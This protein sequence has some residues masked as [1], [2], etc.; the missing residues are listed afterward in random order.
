[1]AFSIPNSASATFPDQARVDAVDID[2]LTA[3]GR[4]NGVV[5]GCAV[6][7]TG[8]ANGSLTIT[9]GLIRYADVQRPVAAATLAVGA[10]ATGNV[11][12]DLVTI[13]GTS[14]VPVVTA[15]TA[16]PNPVFPAVPAGS[17][18]VSVVRV[19]AGH[20]STTVIPANT[21]TDKSVQVPRFP[22]Q[23]P[24]FWTVYGHSFVQYNGGSIDQTGRLD[25]IMR[26]V[27]DIEH[28][29][30]RNH[31]KNGAIGWYQ[32]GGKG[33]WS[34]I[35]QNRGAYQNLA[36]G[37]YPGEGGATLLCYGINDLGTIDPTP[38]IQAALQGFWLA[39]ISR[40]RSGVIYKGALA[41]RTVFG[42]GFGLTTGDYDKG[43]LGGTYYNALSITNANITMT[44]PADYAGEVVA[45][46]FLGSYGGAGA[47][48]LSGTAGVTGTIELANITPSASFS[49]TPVVTRITN[50]TSANA[51]QTI[52]A[53]VSRF[54]AGTSVG[55][56]DWW[57]ESKSPP[58]VLVCNINRPAL[59]GYG[60]YGGWT[61]TEADKD[62]DVTTA[63]ANLAAVV[64]QFDSMVQI[65]DMDA[66][67]GKSP[68]GA[69]TSDG[70]H[71]ND[72]GAALICDQ[73]VK[74]LNNIF[75]VTTRGQT[76]S[77]N[78]PSPRSGNARQPHMRTKWYTTQAR[79][80]YGTSASVVA[81]DM[82]LMPFVV[83]EA[84]EQFGAVAVD[85]INAVAGTAVRL[86]MYDDPA[87]SGY[88]QKLA[89]GGE[90]TSGGALTVLTATGPTTLTIPAFQPRPDPGLYWLAVKFT[91]V[92]TAHTFRCLLGPVDQMTNL[93]SSGAGS[94]T[95]SGY[96]LTGQGTG[97]FPDLC[98]QTGTEVDSVPLVA[99]QIVSN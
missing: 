56:T 92:G 70:L 48:T 34:T 11:R 99:I 1:M 39:A 12:Y 6:S 42:A 97:V 31:A 28:N 93:A 94:I 49:Y 32:G 44:L 62:L 7:S 60:G 73:I 63:N 15:G 96:K 16:A 25:S 37:P 66:V 20:A 45:L 81:G 61:G 71:P 41:G 84:R 18:A 79:K 21:I 35:W 74:A 13:D 27:F 10:N 68:A 53:T 19:P 51:G 54:D 52:V 3:G 90:F 22:M 40:C 89:V 95:P 67:I 43:S 59:A 47:V 29:N 36:A 14:G 57:L 50:L 24:D 88:P 80:G 65:V 86:G 2:I 46:C 98:P 38:Q 64:A 5:S 26:A 9:G 30:W 69:L 8:A 78:T 91:T 17:I 85:A 87:W 23:M 58:P 75:P 77:M 72:L 4:G 33:N 82:Y 76:S 83:T 55:F